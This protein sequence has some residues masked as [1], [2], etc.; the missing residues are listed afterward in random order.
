MC[1]ARPCVSWPSGHVTTMSSACDS[2]KRSHFWLLNTSKSSTSNVW[3]RTSTAGACVCGAGGGVYAGEAP[4]ALALDATKAPNRAAKRDWDTAR[5][6]VM[7]ISTKVISTRP[8][9][10]GLYQ[11]CRYGIAPVWGAQGDDQSPRSH[12]KLGEEEI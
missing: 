6:G 4:C 2:P 10:G 3:S 8:S 7:A 11:H 9:F 1:A 12:R 5:I